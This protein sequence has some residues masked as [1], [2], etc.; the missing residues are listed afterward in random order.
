M[1]LR[2][3]IKPPIPNN[4]KDKTARHTRRPLSHDAKPFKS[5]WANRHVKVYLGSTNNRSQ[6]AKNAANSD[7][8]GDAR[9][10][11]YA[12]PSRGNPP[13]ICKSP[14]SLL[15]KENSPSKMGI[16]QENF[17]V[18][19]YVFLTMGMCLPKDSWSMT[20]AAES[21]TLRGE[22]SLFGVQLLSRYETPLD[23]WDEYDLKIHVS[24]S[25][26]V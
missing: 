1:V 7:S 24:E 17:T 16:A 6:H 15:V 26:A 5:L 2:Y 14:N 3:A 20:G 12:S 23:R 11:S 4:D 9:V 22:Q 25:A 19:V 8:S 18:K 13:R 21:K 10:S